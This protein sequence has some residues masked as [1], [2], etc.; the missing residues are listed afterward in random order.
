MNKLSNKVAVIT[1]ATSRI[2]LAAARRFAAEG[3]RVVLF[4]RTEETVLQ[5]QRSIGGDAIGVHG[6]VSDA[7]ALTRLF[8]EARRIHGRVDVLLSLPEYAPPHA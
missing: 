7:T 8:E 6:D 2:G 5:A 4:A 3:A 1:G